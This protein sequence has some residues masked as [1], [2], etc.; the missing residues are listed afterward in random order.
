MLVLPTV[1]TLL[2]DLVVRRFLLPQSRVLTCRLCSN[3]IE[4]FKNAIEQLRSDS[5]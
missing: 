2:G 1:Q 5:F 3:Q 4:P